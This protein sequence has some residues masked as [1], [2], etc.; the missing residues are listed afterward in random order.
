MLCKSYSYI[1][2]VNEIQYIR[3]I[4]AIARKWVLWAI[5]KSKP[6]KKNSI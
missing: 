1:C 2:G 3:D 5:L 6:L 4:W